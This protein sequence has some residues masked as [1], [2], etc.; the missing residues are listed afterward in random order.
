MKKNPIG[1]VFK[2]ENIFLATVNRPLEK[3]ELEAM[4]KEAKYDP[5]LPES[6]VLLGVLNDI[7]CMQEYD[8]FYKDEKGYTRFLA[9]GNETFAGDGT[10]GKGK[11]YNI[12]SVWEY[13]DEDDLSEVYNEVGEPAI[14]DET[15]KIGKIER[16]NRDYNLKK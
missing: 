1:T 10:D 9:E 12:V 5:N 8:I 3:E 16:Y 13:Y 6:D 4:L 11:F 14:L 7:F 2:K 15:G